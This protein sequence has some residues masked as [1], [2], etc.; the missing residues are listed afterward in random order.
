MNATDDINLK[1][2]DDHLAELLTD[3]M[4]K[5]KFIVISDGAKQGIYDT[6][7][8]ALTEAVA[9]YKPGSFII[10]QVIDPEASINFLFSAMGA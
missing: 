9:K 1:Y 3:P 5:D 10:Q 7:E 4:M 8:R 2:F 6:F